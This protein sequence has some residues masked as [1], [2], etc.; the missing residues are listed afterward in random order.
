MHHI[1]YA[2]FTQLLR[3]FYT[4]LYL[5]T[6]FVKDTWKTSS[7]QDVLVSEKMQDEDERNKMTLGK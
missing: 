3:I 6:F 2:P 5:H 1:L 7:T 4:P